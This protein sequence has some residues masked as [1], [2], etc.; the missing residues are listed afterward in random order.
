M[1]ELGYLRRIA[2][3][4]KHILPNMSGELIPN[5]RPNST[6]L[7]SVRG[8]C[9]PPIRDSTLLHGIEGILRWDTGR[10]LRVRGYP[11]RIV[12]DTLLH[13]ETSGMKDLGTIF[14]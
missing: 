2:E 11:R 6:C 10:S 7:S 8:V 5:E 1:V 12:E 3:S 14:R 13:S 9:V 4:P